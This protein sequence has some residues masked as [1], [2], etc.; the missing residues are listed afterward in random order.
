MS[1]E[2]IEYGTAENPNPWWWTPEDQALA[3]PIL[4]ARVQQWLQDEAP[5]FEQWVDEN[6]PA[7]QADTGTG[8]DEA[9]WQ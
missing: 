6:W 4:Q 9:D 1:N 3:D 8:D 2:E 7:D 5:K